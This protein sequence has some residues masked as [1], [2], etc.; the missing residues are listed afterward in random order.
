VLDDR[1]FIIEPGACREVYKFG[2]K[3]YVRAGGS[4]LR[5]GEYELVGEVNGG[6]YFALKE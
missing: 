4:L 2:R 5:D 3:L 1:H 6:Y